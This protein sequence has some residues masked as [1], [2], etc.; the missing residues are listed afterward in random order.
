MAPFLQMP[1]LL[2]LQTE[3]LDNA[4]TAVPGSIL[5]VRQP[6]AGGTTP[7]TPPVLPTRTPEPMTTPSSKQVPGFT[8]PVAA[9]AI[10]AA[11][12]AWRRL[13]R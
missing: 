3:E 10:G 11:P 1:P 5:A 4:G 8:L 13:F 2:V 6:V 9:C 12:W 7:A